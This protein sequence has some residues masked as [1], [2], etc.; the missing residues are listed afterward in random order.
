MFVAHGWVWVC[1]LG[2]G[3]VVIVG[4]DFFVAGVI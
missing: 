4:V 3:W 2:F 1:G